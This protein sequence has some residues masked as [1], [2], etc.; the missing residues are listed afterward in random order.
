MSTAVAAGKYH[1][2][3]AYD[4][5]ALNKYL[6]FVN[7]MVYDYHGLWDG[8]TG[9]NAPLYYA[10]NSTGASRE[11]TGQFT[12]EYF[13]E[14]GLSS[15]KLV[16]GVPLYGSVFKLANATQNGL[17]AKIIGAGQEGGAYEHV[18]HIKHLKLQFFEL[19]KW[20]ICT[21]VL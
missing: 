6:D 14:K 21:Q 20:L 19:T 3:L 4:I 1:I 2:D 10:V 16:F 18:R 11:L 5:P 9:H 8:V 15:K 17:G 12:V 7:V 13:I